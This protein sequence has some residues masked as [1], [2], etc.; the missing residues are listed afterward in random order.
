MG[1]GAKPCP[2]TGKPRGC[3]ASAEPDSSVLRITFICSLCPLVTPASF[4]G[5]CPAAV[6]GPALPGDTADT[7]TWAVPCVPWG[8]RGV[9]QCCWQ[10]RGHCSSWQGWWAQGRQREKAGG[11]QRGGVTAAPGRAGSQP[12][13]LQQLFFECLGQHKVH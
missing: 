8:A 11:R 13:L 4:G 10:G 1:H 5:S 9:L 7:G 12:F 2:C 3:C 6:N